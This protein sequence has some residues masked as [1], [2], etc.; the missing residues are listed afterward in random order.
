MVVLTIAAQK[1]GETIYFDEPIPQVHFMKLISCSLYNSW[2]NLKKEGSAVLGDEKK[3]SSVSVGK[4]NPGH[5]TLGS[6]AQEIANIFESYRQKLNTK[7]NTPFGQLEITNPSTKPI[8]LD[9]D[10]AELFGVK[11]ELARTTHVGYLRYPTTYF[12]HC[13]LIDAQQNFFNNKRSDLLAKLDVRGKPYEKVSYEASPQQPLRDCSTSSHVNSITV[14][15][16]DE[17]GELFDF[18]GFPL[19]FV[20]EMN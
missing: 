6:M 4:I 14:S 20:L 7:T 15:V 5:Y 10:L 13:D 17:N 18:N 11:R 16:R 1:N 19:E 2:H 9:R 3:D 8:K 12:I